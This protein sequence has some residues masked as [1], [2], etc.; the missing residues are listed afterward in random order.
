MPP[1]EVMGMESVKCVIKNGKRDPF[2]GG[3]IWTGPF[4]VEDTHLQK[5]VLSCRAS[6]GV[7]RRLGVK[8]LPMFAKRVDK[9]SAS[10]VAQKDARSSPKG[11]TEAE[12]K[13]QDY[14]GAPIPG[15]RQ[16][17]CKE[18]DCSTAQRV[19]LQQCSE[20]AKAAVHHHLPVRTQWS[21]NRKAKCLRLFGPKTLLDLVEES[22]LSYA[23]SAAKIGSKWGKKTCL[24]IPS[25]SQS[26][27]KKHILY[28]SLALILSIR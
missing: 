6:K 7:R 26:L 12:H 4:V 11:R 5:T 15:H 16:P 3:G 24:G 18:C 27:L 1:M 20:S 14:R 28:Q 10:K 23:S 13:G 9:G 22:S 2:P 17:D 21:S 8:A 19:G 25:D